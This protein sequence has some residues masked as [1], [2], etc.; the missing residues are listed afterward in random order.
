M[1]EFLS[2]SNISSINTTKSVAKMP[3]FL[4]YKGAKITR[5][6]IQL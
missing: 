2:S 6:V 5:M 3:Y 4:N 1:A